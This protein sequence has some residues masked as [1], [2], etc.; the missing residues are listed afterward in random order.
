MTHPTPTPSSCSRVSTHIRG[1]ASC[2]DSTPELQDGP[3]AGGG[4]RRGERPCPGHQQDPRDAPGCFSAVTFNS[5][6][7]YRAPCAAGRRDVARRGP[8]NSGAGARARFHRARPGT[9]VPGGGRRRWPAPYF[10]LPETP[11]PPLPPPR[12]PRTPHLLAPVTNT[13]F[14]MVSRP[15]ALPRSR[16][17]PLPREQWKP[18]ALLGHAHA[19]AVQSGPD[20]APLASSALLQSRP[21]VRSRRRAPGGVR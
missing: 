8:G 13:A 17:P 1:A 4:G 14:R 16:H 5:G 21:A 20:G 3:G 9:R 18:E 7:G 15:A 2:T 6:T 19:A 12:P 11:D 10:L